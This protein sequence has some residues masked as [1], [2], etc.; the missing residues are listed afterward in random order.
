MRL[1]K[2]GGR[3]SGRCFR[4]PRNCVDDHLTM[5]PRFLSLLISLGFGSKPQQ[6]L[7]QATMTMRKP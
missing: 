7:P 6:F 4:W 3:I 2:N 1:G 5:S